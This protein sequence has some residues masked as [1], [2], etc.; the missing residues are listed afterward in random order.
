MKVNLSLFIWSYYT[1]G[2]CRNFICI[3]NKIF[4]SW[5]NLCYKIRDSHNL[6]YLV[7]L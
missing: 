2:L 4:G 7:Q 5:T 3:T 6:E 1:T